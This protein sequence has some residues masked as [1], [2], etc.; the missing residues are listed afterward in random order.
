MHRFNASEELVRRKE[1]GKWVMEE[2]KERQ[3]E[4]GAGKEEAKK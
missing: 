2:R 4:N 3:C 1:G